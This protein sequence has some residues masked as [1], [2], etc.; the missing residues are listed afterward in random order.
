MVVPPSDQPKSPLTNLGYG[1]A[2][3]TDHIQP[4]KALLDAI[5]FSDYINRT[6]FCSKDIDNQRIQYC[7]LIEQDN[8][9]AN[10]LK[11]YLI[12]EVDTLLFSYNLTSLSV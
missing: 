4:T 2:E 6:L 5:F 8:I 12:P 10:N 9:L 7:N 11:F 3:M 1:L